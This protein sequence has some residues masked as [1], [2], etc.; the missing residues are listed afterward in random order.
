MYVCV[1]V[2][3]RFTRKQYE[4]VTRL[5]NTGL[6]KFEMVV[7]AKTKIAKTTADSKIEERKLD[8]QANENWL[9]LIVAG[10]G[11]SSLCH[12]NLS[13]CSSDVT[14]QHARVMELINMLE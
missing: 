12:L 3:H 4:Q 1:Y 2:H 14:Y 9:L 10:K 7:T 5:N 6:R 11:G 8:T 13:T